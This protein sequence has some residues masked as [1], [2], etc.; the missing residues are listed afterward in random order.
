MPQHEVRD[1]LRRIRFSGSLLASVSTETNRKPQWIE[2]ELYTHEPGDEYPG[3]YFLHVIGRSVRYHQNGSECNTGVPTPWE[4]LPED[5]EPC[6]QC[7]PPSLPLPGTP[8]GEGQAVDLE[9]DR[10]TLHDCETTADVVHK[11]ARGGAG[12]LSAPAQRL[13]E[14]AAQADRGLAAALDTTQIL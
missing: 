4:E 10:H 8:R 11:L 9:S 2:L 12:K 5:A 14:I 13:L 1:G 6:P 3:R 7:R